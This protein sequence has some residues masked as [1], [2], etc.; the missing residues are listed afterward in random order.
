MLRA[1]PID[2]MIDLGQKRTGRFVDIDYVEI[3][4]DNIRLADADS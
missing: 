1:K 2:T 3:I 4:E